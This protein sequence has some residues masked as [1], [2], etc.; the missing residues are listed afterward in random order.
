[1]WRS[2]E[3]KWPQLP[4]RGSSRTARCC[5]NHLRD[6]T[7]FEGIMSASVQIVSS[8]KPSG[9]TLLRCK[10]FLGMISGEKASLHLLP[11]RGDPP[12][13]L[14]N[15]LWY[16]QIFPGSRPWISWEGYLS[17]QAS[18]L[19]IQIGWPQ[20]VV[21]AAMQ[22]SGLGKCRSRFLQLISST[23]VLRLE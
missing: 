21:P 4:A 20:T 2:L 6:L 14:S 8:R 15:T 22:Q 16:P 5:R 19:E 17:H 13:Y 11:T 18:I 7:S 23:R 10:K 1:M 3:F 12:D 9:N